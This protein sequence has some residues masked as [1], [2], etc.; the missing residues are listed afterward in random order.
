[1]YTPLNYA[2]ALARWVRAPTWRKRPDN[3]RILT[4]RRHRSK[5]IVKNADDSVSFRFH[6]TD[7]VTYRPDGDVIVEPYASVTTDRFASCYLPLYITAKFHQ[8]ALAIHQR[9]VG[10]R[11]IESRY[12]QAVDTMHLKPSDGEYAWDVVEPKPWTRKVPDPQKARAARETWGYSRFRDVFQM[13]ATLLGNDVCTFTLPSDW[14]AALAAMRDGPEKWGVFVTS[15]K[16][17]RRPRVFDGGPPYTCGTLLAKLREIIY[18]YENAYATISL[19]FVTSR[20]AFDVVRKQ[21]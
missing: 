10:L 9:G 4:R 12:Y 6:D 13:R 11:W 15:P 16:Q 8:R 18:D 20:S 1:M 7:V 5:M 21:S 17:F 14:R 19:P 2:E 3:M